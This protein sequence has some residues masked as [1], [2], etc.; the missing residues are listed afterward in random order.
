MTT[1]RI[2]MKQNSLIVMALNFCHLGHLIM[3]R[4]FAHAKEIFRVLTGMYQ[5]FAV[6]SSSEIKELYHNGLHFT[7]DFTETGAIGD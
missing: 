2:E 4:F 3:P 1:E 7:L 6:I 5:I